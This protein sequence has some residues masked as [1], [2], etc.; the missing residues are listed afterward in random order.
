MN[1]PSNQ[2]TCL[3]REREMTDR[4]RERAK[5]G[6]GGSARFSPERGGKSNCEMMRIILRVFYFG[7]G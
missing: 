1:L 3:G 5:D 6:I 4:Q 7:W 2:P